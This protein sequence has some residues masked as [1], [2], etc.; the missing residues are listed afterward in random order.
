[1]RHARLALVPV[2]NRGA[3]PT[4]EQLIEEG[5]AAERHGQ[6][7]RA[8]ECYEDALRRLSGESGGRRASAVLRWIAR[9]YQG[10]AEMDAA[11]DCLAAAVAV[12]EAWGDES[13]AGSAI[14]VEAVVRW[15][16][17]DLDEAERLYRTARAR[18]MRAGDAKLAAMTAQNLGVIANVRGDLDEA[19]RRYEASLHEYRAL[20]LAKDICVAL[21][22]LGLLHTHQEQWEEAERAFG[23]A[24][25]I[26]DG[27]GDLAAQM[28]LE[29]NLAEMWVARHEY[30]RAQQVV[31]HA[32]ELASRTG[33]GSAI[34]QVTKLLGV[35]ARETGDAEEAEQQFRRA[36]EIAVARQDILLEAEVARE[37]ADLARRQGRNSQVLQHLNRAH[38]LFSQLRARRDLADID[39]R[40]GH[41]EGDFLQVARRWGESIEAK[42]RYTQGH[43]VRVA[44]LACAIA[45]D[46]GLEAQALFWFRIG[47]LLHDV[48]KLMIPEEVLNKPGKLTDEEWLLM[49]GHTTAGVEM[50]SDIEFPWDVLPIV[51]SHHERWDGRGYPEGLQGE[52]I[53][54]VARILCI[55]DVY[56]ALTSVR[57]Y[58]RALTHEEALEIM[59][60][61]VGT[62]FDPTLFVAFERV[63]TTWSARAGRGAA[64]EDV[65]SAEPSDVSRPG[66]RPV[67][68]E[69]DELTRLPLRRAFRETAERVLE[70]RRTTE[71]PASLLVVDIDQ[72]DLV[73]DTFGHLQGDDVLRLVADV[74]RVQLQPSDL[75]AR[76]SGD[77]FVILLPGTQLENAVAIGERLRSAVDRAHC[78]PRAGA[79]V[80]VTVSIGAAAAPLHG[81][82]LDALFAAADGALNASKSRGRNAVTAANVHAP[83]YAPLLARQGA[84]TSSG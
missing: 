17:G 76:Y 67:T 56:D 58:K 16:Q 71:R 23:E 15:Q 64:A 19:R 11:L 73:N 79:S 82:T 77:E 43:C 48:G 8:R 31:R 13:A 68:A 44:D 9:T 2:G 42:D 18:A 37:M 47:A 65:A 49:R 7:A 30:G 62:M 63:A 61:D 22:N 54:L 27:V 33:D 28:L 25:Q 36:Q 21:N 38:R 50:L 55:A 66:A 41:L 69:V 29:V 72:L 75:V 78:V 83:G 57:S 39:R 6:R 51:R 12:A 34:G 35:I 14:N 59:R 60:G 10:D 74:I 70:A 1:M 80:H 32:M 53:P 40:N 5:Q 24:V 4:A 81:E 20:G 84:D 52:E 3:G 46:T 45:A 26:S